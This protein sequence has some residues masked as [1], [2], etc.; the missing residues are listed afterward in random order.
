MNKKPKRREIRF[1]SI[2]EAVADAERLA[3]G[4][5]ETTGRYSFGQILDHL[6]RAMDTVSG[7]LVPPPVALPLRL[8]A[9]L[10]RGPMIATSFRPGF[11]LPAKTQSLLWS[12]EPVDVATGLKNWKASIE[13]YKQAEPLQPHPV[14][15][16]MSREK[17]NQVQCRHS[18]LHLSFVHPKT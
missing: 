13:R 9:R 7:E 14:F 2:E 11:K 6:G 16:K 1:N 3:A 17:H 15:G 4:E 5:V 10:I 18:E 8:A 12:S